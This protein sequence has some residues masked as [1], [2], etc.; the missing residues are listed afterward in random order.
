MVDFSN[1]NIFVPILMVTISFGLVGLCWPDLLLQIQY[2]LLAGLVL[3]IG[4]PH[5]ATD[6]LLFRRLNGPKLSRK[7][8]FRFF[9]FYILA[10]FGYL[11]VWLFFPMIA[12]AS[13]LLISAY[14]F[15]QSNWQALPVPYSLRP[16]LNIAFGAFAIGGAV[17]WHWDEGCPIVRQMIG[18]FPV[19]SNTLMAN[20]QWLILLLNVVMLF[21][22]RLN[23]H[24]DRSILFSEVLKLT[25][26]S[27]MFYFTPLLVGFTLYFTLWH[28]LSSLLD[29]VAF[30]RH[31]WPSFTLSNY[32]CQAAPYTLLAVFGLIGLVFGQSI[33]FP[34]A[35]ILSLFLI[36]IACVTLPH[37][38]LVEERYK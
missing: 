12:L 11:A 2:P 20:I 6:F 14:H 17:L 27:F 29:Q 19:W 30:F 13:F 32:Y 10:V 36:L 4:L 18:D 3:L 5:G 8:V 37:I 26:L 7:Q 24:I 1:K 34:Q 16:V 22:L 35:S 33:L 31:Q 23:G 28:S 38:V 21:G 15:G 25:T 9:L